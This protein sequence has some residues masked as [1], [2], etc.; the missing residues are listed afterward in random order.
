M[1][2]PEQLSTFLGMCIAINLLMGTGYLALPDVFYHAGIP[3]SFAI[4]SLLALLMYVSCCQ[5][6]RSVYRAQAQHHFK[7]VPEVTEA[8]RMYGGQFLSSSYL[9]ILSMSLV[10]SVWAYAVLF[11]QSIA[12]ELPNLYYYVLPLG[13]NV[14]CVEGNKFL[15][16][17]S[18][19]Q[20][21]YM[22]NLVL[23]ALITTPLSLV[24]LRDQ[25]VFQSVMTGIR[26]ILMV[27]MCLILL[28]VKHLDQLAYCFPLS[29][30]P[31]DAAT[32]E[33]DRQR[34]G[35][36]RSL[37]AC[38]SACIFALYINGAIPI[39]AQA[40]A[41]DDWWRCSA[42]TTRDEH[43]SNLELMHSRARRTQE[44]LET[45]VGRAIV[46]A[47]L[48]YGALALVAGTC[49]AERIDNPANLNWSGFRW[50]IA[51]SASQD[52]PVSSFSS[53][54]ANLVEIFVLLFP[55]LD[56]L[57]AYPLTTKVLAN[58]LLESI[59]GVE[60]VGAVD[61]EFH[62][63]GM[64]AMCW[65]LFAL[66]SYSSPHAYSSLSHSDLPDIVDDLVQ[67]ASCEFSPFTLCIVLWMRIAINILPLLC[68]AWFPNF[69]SVI[70][71][72]GGISV[73]ICLVYPALLS[74]LTVSAHDSDSSGS[75]A[76]SVVNSNGAIG[77]Y[78]AVE[79][80][81]AE[82]VR[83]G[84]GIERGVLESRYVQLGTLTLG[85]LLSVVII[86]LA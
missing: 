77:N 48:L 67:P 60:V 11:G 40:M 17:N 47:C 37:F 2:E 78:G 28:W 45:V 68:A 83:H 18:S 36:W 19:C 8:L 56:V 86:V 85:A 16:D 22:L 72:V 38:V 29:F 32:I 52:A 50:P 63:G 54:S 12:S 82:A 57:N 84:T 33:I 42:G 43:R 25:A 70:N 62:R 53:A 69:S 35:T 61:S 6:G 10:G 26:V 1:S 59:F 5:E 51:E 7:K 9:F 41:I 3:V 80:M 74:I 76:S 81:K 46:V 44:G 75:L 64:R 13:D 34:I 14:H 58:N 55:V 24:Q 65:S 79:P 15:S 23:L 73:V 4:M 21:R 31:V 27:T 66:H 30:V 49:F 39:V 71:Y 20:T